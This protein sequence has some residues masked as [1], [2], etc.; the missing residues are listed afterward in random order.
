MDEPLTN[1]DPDLK[2][3]LLRLLKETASVEGTT[4]LYVTH[5]NKEANEI[6]KGNLLEMVNGRIIEL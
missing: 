3:S 2:E 6:A 1:V 4:L 5:D